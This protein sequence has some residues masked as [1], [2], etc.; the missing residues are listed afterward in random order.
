[1]TRM[2][3]RR[4]PRGAIEQ[5]VSCLRSRLAQPPHWGARLGREGTA[6]EDGCCRRQ[7]LPRFLRVLRGDRRAR[8]GYYQTPMGIT[9]SGRT[10]PLGGRFAPQRP[11]A[12]GRAG[13]SSS[14]TH[15]VA[16][17]ARLTV[18][19]SSCP[20]I[21]A[22]RKTRTSCSAATHSQSNSTRVRASRRPSPSAASMAS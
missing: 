22:E 10:C 11:K 8:A 13:A 3:T 16:L 9:H 2:R 20:H 6:D 5:H 21:P 1:M 15:L 7:L 17:Q 14:Q 4:R 19:A 12:T 18:S